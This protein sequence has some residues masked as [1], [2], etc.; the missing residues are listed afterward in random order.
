MTL[1]KRVWLIACILSGLAV[2]LLGEPRAAQAQGVERAWQAPSSAAPIVDV[3]VAPAYWRGKTVYILTE[4]DLYRTTDGGN[5][6][7]RLATWPEDMEELEE[8]TLRAGAIAETSEQ[9]HI[10]WIADSS[11]GVWRVD[12]ATAIWLP[13]ASPATGAPS[14]PSSDP[15]A[16][17]FGPLPPSAQLSAAELTIA[18]QQEV[19]PD[20][21][22]QSMWLSPDGGRL[23]V[24]SDQSLFCVYDA[25]TLE[26]LRCVDSAET[27]ANID[28]ERIT[29][30]PDG[31]KLALTENS[32]VYFYDSDIWVFDTDSGQFTNLT[33][34][35]VTGSII[36]L[37][38]DQMPLVDYMPLWSPD[39]Q[40]I[41]F[42]RST[43]G[44]TKATDLYAVASEGGEP[45]KV[46]ALGQT[47]FAIYGTM[48]WSQDG[49]TLYFSRYLP[50]RDDPTNGIWRYDTDNRSLEQLLGPEEERGIP[51][52]RGVN[53]L[54]G[55]VLV[56]Y[57][58]FA[59]QYRTPSRATYALLDLATAELSDLLPA[60]EGEDLFPHVIGATLSP[61]GSKILFSYGDSQPSFHVAV[62]DVD[63]TEDNVLMSDTDLLGASRVRGTDLAWAND[64]TVLIMAVDTGH[65]GQLANLRLSVQSPGAVDRD[66]K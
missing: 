57:P 59:A 18:A 63:G 22:V 8:I 32:P 56:F 10:L 43:M 19:A 45:R 5:S 20:E 25:V 51:M 2:F 1:Q 30:S 37:E 47:P 58:E 11:G 64:D 4:T 53:T 27:I 13:L 62:R 54:T 17:P 31:R 65:L 41:Y 7:S 12:P 38:A 49:T 28:Y 16:A 39:G 9:G 42:A 15:E 29:W 23:V 21:L 34:D 60:V 33:D 26:E 44:D 14:T 36:T 35:G 52:V 6:W 46:L 55:K 50:Q 40:E 48:Y 3:L 24:I 66:G 61:D